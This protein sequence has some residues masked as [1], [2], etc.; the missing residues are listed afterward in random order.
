MKKT[1]YPIV[2]AGLSL[3]SISLACNMPST[4]VSGSETPVTTPSPVETASPVISPTASPTQT[5]TPEPLPS[6]TSAPATLT[7]RFPPIC[8]RS[9]A[10]TLAAPLCQSPVAEQSSVFCMSKKPYNLIL[11]NPGATY[12][13]L[14]EGFECVEAGMKDERRILMC[15][16]PMGTSYELKVC[17][18]QAC[19]V[20]TLPAEPS[21]CPPE[22][23][24]DE[25][26][27][28][29]AFIPQPLEESC[30]LLNL[31]TKSC[32]TN[33]AAYK[34][35]DDCNNHYHACLWNDEE[36]VCQVRP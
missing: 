20:P 31:Q 13:V 9:V 8:E 16:G 22:F 23:W 2:L 28:C 7:P 18:Q 32:V 10:S 12:E 27:G 5:A 33:C 34:K 17:G 1:L 30:I 35:V 24:Y 19:S 11:L 15:N 26:Q 21:Q 29:C 14:S 6:P 3:V 25:S 36:L 4:Q